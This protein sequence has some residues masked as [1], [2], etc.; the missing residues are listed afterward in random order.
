MLC[1]LF[2]LVLDISLVNITEFILWNLKTFNFYQ[3]KAPVT[4][5]LLYWLGLLVLPDVMDWPTI[6]LVASGLTA[7][8]ALMFT[9]LW[10]GWS[11]HTL[12]MSCH[13]K[14]TL[15]GGAPFYS[16]W[17]CLPTFAACVSHFH[18]FVY[19]SCC[20]RVLDPF[21]LSYASFCGAW[22]STLQVITVLIHLYHH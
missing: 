14:G 9:S 19:F 11:S 12:Y 13:R 17:N 20:V 21:L 22:S 3:V 4:L 10:S 5:F 7:V 2:L 18:I 6:S 16:T 15:S 8:S 1:V